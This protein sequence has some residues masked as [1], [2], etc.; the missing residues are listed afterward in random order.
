MVK[1]PREYED[2]DP[3]KTNEEIKQL[4]ETIRPDSDISIQ[5]REGTP[6][7]LQYTLLEHQKLGLAWMKSMEE[8]DQKGGILADDMGLGKTI[9]AI[10]LMASRPSED[11]ARKP[12]L[13]IAPVALMQQWKREIERILRPG[14][15]QLSIYVLHG[16][17]RAVTF[18]DI[19]KYDVV[20]TTF[21]TLASELKRKE[22]YDDRQKAGANEYI[23][24]ELAKSLPCL[25]PSSLWYRI[26]IDEAQ[27]I[28]N[29]NTK[30]AIACCQLNAT[31]RWCM[32]GTPM[33]NNV[34]ELHSLLKFLRIRPYNNL[35]R[36]NRVGVPLP[37]NNSLKKEVTNLI[38][39]FHQASQERK[40]RRTRSSD[41]AAPSS[42]EGRSPSTYQ[43]IQ[44]RWP[45]HPATAASYL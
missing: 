18:R 20:L 22:H 21:G 2:L 10:A 19:K 37:A 31:Y 34:E 38:S 44:D 40:S 33:M 45:T 36:F 5:N 42:P 7:A 4:L 11:P 30:A 39:G 23:L 28:K 14:K 9:Q 15:Y 16:E 6:E 43:R 17:K 32:S 12:T 26:I 35:E 27:C 13:I 8:K 25:G 24:Q 29:R 41:D 3:K 1:N